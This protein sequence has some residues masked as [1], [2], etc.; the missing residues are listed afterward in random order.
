MCR[1]SQEPET[2]SFLLERS[3]FLR[4]TS[5]LII[6]ENLAIGSTW[7]NISQWVIIHWLQWKQK[8]DRE[9]SEAEQTWEDMV[10]WYVI[11]SYCLGEDL[12]STAHGR[13]LVVLSTCD[14]GP[15]SCLQHRSLGWCHSG[16]SKVLE[17]TGAEK[18][19][20]YWCESSASANAF[21]LHSSAV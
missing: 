10:Y 3:I 15:V 6:V 21:F 17:K 2:K 12:M 8:L 4:P 5:S 11:I 1:S 14:C 18:Y 19:P 20:K 16:K 13:H 7:G 9:E